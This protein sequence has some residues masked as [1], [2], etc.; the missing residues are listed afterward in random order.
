MTY[1]L[2][3]T[4]LADRAQLFAMLKDA[5][6]LPE[7]CGEN[8]DALHDVLSEGGEKTLA[9]WNVNKAD[10]SLSGYLASLCGMLA[11]LAAENPEFSFSWEEK[12]LYLARV[13]ALRA[14]TERHNNCA[15]SVLLPFV[16]D[17]GLDEEV[18]YSLAA[19][20][21]S[22]MKRAS[23]CGAVTGG[24][25]ALGLLG[26]DDGPT[27]SAYHSRLKAAHDGMLE[28]AD[29]LRADK[30]R[31]GEKKVHCDGMVYECVAL[32]EEIL[33]ERGII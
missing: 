5:L 10:A 20:F 31:G 28:C 30:E 9:F 27:V 6:G 1:D 23:V 2:D 3:L 4:G 11:E 19:N 22:G 14:D 32:V 12:S 13:E 25:M 7:Y 16:A 18:A 8:L 26:V 17:V 21:G 33:R 24:L 29:L 15:Q